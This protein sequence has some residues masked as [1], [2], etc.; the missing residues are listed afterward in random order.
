MRHRLRFHGTRHAPLDSRLSALALM[1]LNPALGVLD[2][3]GTNPHFI[4]ATSRSPV[5][6]LNLTTGWNESG[7]ML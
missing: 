2:Q 5:S 7:V 4:W 6:W 1:E 3:Y